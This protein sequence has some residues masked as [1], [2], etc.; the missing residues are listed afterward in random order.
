VATETGRA[1]SYKPEVAIELC[2]V[3]RWPGWNGVLNRIH[4]WV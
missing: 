4:W 3:E 1:R 2:W